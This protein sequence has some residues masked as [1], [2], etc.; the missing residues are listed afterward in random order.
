MSKP[1]AKYC[2]ENLL[3]ALRDEIAELIRVRRLGDR[4][5][6]NYFSGK[7]VGLLRACHIAGAITTQQFGGVCDFAHGLPLSFIGPVLRKKYGAKAGAA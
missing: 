4:Q 2:R 5:R 6:E 3:A 7:V 1:T